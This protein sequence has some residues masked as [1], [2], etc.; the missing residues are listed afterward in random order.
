M[1]QALASR[2]TAILAILI[3]AFALRL[4]M[5]QVRPLWYD[6]AFTVLISE[7]GPA[8]IALGLAADTTPPGY[9]LLLYGWMNLTGQAPLAMRMLSVCLSML[10]VAVAY[11][12][13]KRGFGERAGQWTA[14][15]VALTPFQIYH[16][17]ELRIYTLLGLGVVLY[18]YGVLLWVRE[19]ALRR[20]F[21]FIV[22]GVTV[23][24]Y[25]HNLAFVSLLAGNVYFAIQALRWRVSWRLQWQLVAAQFAGAVFFLP[26]LLYVPG[27]V[28]KIQRAFWTARP[29][30]VDVLQLL[31]VFTTYLPLPPL[32]V[33]VVLFSTLVLVVLASWLLF[34]RARRMPMPAL[35]LMLSFA[36]V[37]PI[38]LFVVSY[39]IRPVFIPRG[40]IAAQ[41]AYFVL[42]GALAGF[43]SRRLQIGLVVGGLVGAGILLPFYYFS[44]GEWRRAP[45]VQADAFLR[46]QLRAGDVVL[47]DNKLSFF[48]MHLYDRALPQSYL[49]DP[50]GSDNDT[51]APA[52][53]AAMELYPA[54]FEDAVNTHPRVWFVIYQT[55]IEEAVPSG[56][57]HP[58]ITRLEKQFTRVQETSYGDLRILLY[59]TR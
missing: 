58:N 53:Q 47:H 17:Q 3:L 29:G 40:I 42:L 38:L 12:L 9:F 56:Q 30:I 4:N 50:P 34:K 26:W 46:E 21:G 44:Y 54:T 37:P 8:A 43:A 20:A 15:L 25:A 14:L 18:M 39:V 32:L 45:F 55:A 24:L 57:L 59:T 51:L 41:V 23:A 36:L 19:P 10:V 49:A 7:R 6:D 31:I 2:Y 16:A 5:L 27:Q 28:E 13:G 48:P 33:P 52:S 1:K 22:V 11:V 35:G